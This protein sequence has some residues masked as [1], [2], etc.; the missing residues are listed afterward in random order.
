[1]INEESNA[2][3]FTQNK[4]VHRQNSGVW[5]SYLSA[6]IAYILIYLTFTLQEISLRDNIGM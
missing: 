4:W 6:L 1:M 5:V 2:L 3:L